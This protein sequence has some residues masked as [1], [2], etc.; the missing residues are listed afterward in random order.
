MTSTVYMTLAPE[1]NE[2]FAFEIT[3]PSAFIRVLVF[4]YDEVSGNDLLGEVLSLQS[5]EV[6]AHF[7]PN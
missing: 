5:Q 3:E 7:G 4:D 6:L 2:S 1:W